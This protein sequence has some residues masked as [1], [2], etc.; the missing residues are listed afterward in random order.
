MVNQNYSLVKPVAI[1]DNAFGRLSSDIDN[2]LDSYD[3]QEKSVTFTWNIQKNSNT[4][5]FETM[6]A[7]SADLGNANIFSKQ[8]TLVPENVLNEIIR[9]LKMQQREVFN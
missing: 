1:V 6:E 9:S 7:H 5:T 8:I 3:Q 2:N 4:S